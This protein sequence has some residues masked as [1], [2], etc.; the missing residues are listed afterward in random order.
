MRPET[1]LGQP[2]DICQPQALAFDGSDIPRDSGQLQCPTCNISCH[3]NAK[4]A[5]FVCC[6]H[7]TELQDVWGV[8]GA[9][10]HD[11]LAAWRKLRCQAHACK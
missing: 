8:D 6:T 11:D 9:G 5:E 3:R 1:A 10:T 4:I 7:A 2:D